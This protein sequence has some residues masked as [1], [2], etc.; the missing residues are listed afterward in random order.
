[1]LIIKLYNKSKKSLSKEY[2]YQILKEAKNRIF[3]MFFAIV[4]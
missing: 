1:M 2:A 3:K 4:E